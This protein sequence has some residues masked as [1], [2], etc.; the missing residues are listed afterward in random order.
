MSVKLSSGQQQNAFVWSHKRETK[1]QKPLDFPL[2]R[3]YFAF[4]HQ[5]KIT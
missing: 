1:L 4:R 5:A 2:K 3:S